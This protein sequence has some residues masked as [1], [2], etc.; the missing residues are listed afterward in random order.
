MSATIKAKQ[1]AKK[2]TRVEIGKAAGR[3]LRSRCGD[4]G[5]TRGKITRNGKRLEYKRF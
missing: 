2:A 3:T 5:E 4:H 1:L